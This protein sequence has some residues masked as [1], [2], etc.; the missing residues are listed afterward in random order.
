MDTAKE[1]LTNPVVVAS[2]LTAVALLV[3]NI[4]TGL[5]QHF[6]EKNRL[7]HEETMASKA[8]KS[9]AK[10]D[11]AEQVRLR[12]IEKAA[13]LEGHTITALTALTQS[14]GVLN[15]AVAVKGD[16]DRLKKHLREFNSIQEVSNSAYSSLTLH[17]AGLGLACVEVI[18]SQLELGEALMRIVVPPADLSDVCTH[19]FP[20]SEDELEDKRRQTRKF[21]SAFESAARQRLDGLRDP[22]VQA[23]VLS[24]TYAGQMQGNAVINGDDS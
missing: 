7:A 3:Q 12:A 11:L 15:R 18:H 17:D 21:L 8:R 6:R 13:A 14:N 20:P 10:A 9:Q 23:N 16:T 22:K 2:L 24:S 4:I 1:L 19:P 5:L